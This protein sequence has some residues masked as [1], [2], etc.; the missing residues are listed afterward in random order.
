MIAARRSITVTDFN[1]NLCIV[2]RA[3]AC[4]SSDAGC[5][6]HARYQAITSPFVLAYGTQGT[7]ARPQQLA[8]NCMFKLWDLVRCCALLRTLLQWTRC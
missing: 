1:F 8:I 2:C 4:S 3:R 6:R 5:A 7:A